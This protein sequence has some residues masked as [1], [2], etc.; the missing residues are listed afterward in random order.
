MAV[1]KHDDTLIA[2]SKN[3]AKIETW[4]SFAGSENF[5]SR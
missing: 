5:S 4:R 3:K 1:D 2:N